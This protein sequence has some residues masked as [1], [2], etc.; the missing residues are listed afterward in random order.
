[1]THRRSFGPT[2]PLTS[3]LAGGGADGNLKPSNSFVH[4]PPGN[5]PAMSKGRNWP[6]EEESVVVS[7]RIVLIGT[8]R[9][10]RRCGRRPRGE[11]T[12]GG[13]LEH[14]AAVGDRN[15]VGVDDRDR[16]AGGA[17][18]PLPAGREG[19]AGAGDRYG[20][21]EID[22]SGAPVA[23]R[24]PM[25]SSSRRSPTM[26]SKSTVAVW[27]VRSADARAARGRPANRV[28]SSKISAGSGWG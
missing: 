1:L 5:H 23:D 7:G 14:G 18:L 6:G 15:V 22:P 3:T 19:G 2:R 28:S 20:L 4:E 9:S 16:E 10:S 11:P 21:R 25:T 27:A 12:R 8:A 17:V 24:A 13:E 26:A